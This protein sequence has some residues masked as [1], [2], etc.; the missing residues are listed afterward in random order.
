MFINHFAGFRKTL[1]EQEK[2]QPPTFA[3]VVTR[4][5]LG[6]NFYWNGQAF[7]ATKTFTLNKNGKKMTIRAATNV[8]IEKQ[9]ASKLKGPPKDD[10]IVPVVIGNE[11]DP[12]FTD[13]S[14][15]AHGKPSKYAGNVVEVPYR[16]FLWMIQP[17]DPNGGGAGGAPGGM[18]LGGIPPGGAP[19][20]APGG[21]PLGGIP[22]G[23]APPG[24]PP[25]GGPPGGGAPPPM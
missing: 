12:E 16:S 21:M 7:P 1:L 4:D 9:F 10:D 6:R 22:P 19:G 11:A 5:Y 2:Q 17:G 15:T 20:G 14:A 8:A 18:P 3:S 25:P 24:G 13:M 23:G